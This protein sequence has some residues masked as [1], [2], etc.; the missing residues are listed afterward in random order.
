MRLPRRSVLIAAAGLLLAAALF[1]LKINRGMVDFNV[2]Y[3]AGDRLLHGE[4]LY[5]VSDEHY[6]FKYAPFCAMIYA[7]LALLPPAA[8][9]A[10]WY[11]LILASIVVLISLTARLLPTSTGKTDTTSA[12]LAGLILAK[13]LLREVQLGQINAIITALL[14]VMVFN[15]ERDK[16]KRSPGRAVSAGLLWGLATAMKPYAAIFLPYFILKRRWNVLA[17]ALAAFGLTLLVPAAYYGFS[18]NLAVHEE[19]IV[20][21]SAS[22][23]ALFDSQDNV[24]LLAML[25]KWM[26]SPG[27]AQ[28]LYLVL[29]LALT[30]IVFSYIRRGRELPRAAVSESFLL[31]LLI[32][33]VSP[34][35]WDYTF[36]SALPAV[37]L[38][39]QHFRNLPKALRGILVINLAVIALSLYDLLGR[40]AYAAFMDA[41]ILTLNF[42]VIAVL[43]GY[44]RWTRKT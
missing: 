43:M 11:V 44:L 5:R 37:A 15:L 9:R 26:S 31:L 42:L 16:A 12:L 27:L 23:P 4:T 21:L 40:R 2:N 8:A 1:P 13:F 25:T 20:S 6:Q 10:V 18:G 30:F 3:A 39:L 36:L 22:T 33:L 19:W 24:S 7:P 28:L 38:L 29:V 32:P 17:A 41:S 14:M 34:L 35:G